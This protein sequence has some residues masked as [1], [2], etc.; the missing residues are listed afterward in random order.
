MSSESTE[1]RIIFE[2][3]FTDSSNYIIDGK[4]IDLDISG[5]SAEYG[6]VYKD[7]LLTNAAKKEDRFNVYYNNGRPYV[8]LYLDMRFGGSFTVLIYLNEEKQESNNLSNNDSL[9]D[10]NSTLSL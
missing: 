6:M 8:I 4:Y 2:G 10:Y 3:C 5:L 7:S 9:I 1:E